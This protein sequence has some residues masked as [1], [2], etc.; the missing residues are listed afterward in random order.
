MPKVPK[1]NVARVWCG[2]MPR[3]GG[4]ENAGTHMM[5]CQACRR[6]KRLYWQVVGE[7]GRAGA[8]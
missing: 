3:V 2:V 6:R 8:R 5:F 1:L 7:Q 4:A